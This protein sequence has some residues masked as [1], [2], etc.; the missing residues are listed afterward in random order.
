MVV[1]TL[2][3]PRLDPDGVEPLKEAFNDFSR[4]FRT[5]VRISMTDSAT[6]SSLF[7]F[8]EHHKGGGFLITLQEVICL[9]VSVNKV[10]EGEFL[11]RYRDPRY[12]EI[13]SVMINVR[14]L[15]TIDN[16]PIRINWLGRFENLLQKSLRPSFSVLSA[17][18]YHLVLPEDHVYL[19]AD[20]PK[21]YGDIL[22]YI[23]S[24]AQYIVPG[25][26]TR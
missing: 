3:D 4:Y 12:S 20:D 2:M 10:K 16:L 26:L 25:S 6:T 8:F 13:R 14:R 11:C 17:L 21:Y 23:F 9:G 22:A 1:L 15:V 7:I 18:D 24:K 5:Q 19:T